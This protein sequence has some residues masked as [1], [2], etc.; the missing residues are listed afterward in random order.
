MYASI[1]LDGHSLKQT[2]KFVYLG[3]TISSKEGSDVD[4]Q[5]RITL[6]RGIFHALNKVWI[7]KDLKKAT[8]IEVFET[9]VLSVL[10]YNSETWN[11]K[12]T[13]KR[14]IRV[15]EMAYASEKSKESQE[16]TDYEIQGAFFW[17]LPIPECSQKYLLAVLLTSSTSGS[18]HFIFRK[19]GRRRCAEEGVVFVNF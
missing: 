4:V 7:S 14:R 18:E 11:M 2:G 15:F 13:S 1:F 16:E 17:D 8:K 6:A 5:R 19:K 3:G 10:L 9:L 12:A